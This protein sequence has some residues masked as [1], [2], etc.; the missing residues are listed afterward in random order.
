MENSFDNLQK[1]VSEINGYAQALQSA[2]EAAFNSWETLTR[3]PAALKEEGV[4]EQIF[5]SYQN[6]Q[7]VVEYLEKDLLIFE[8][9]FRER[10]KRLETDQPGQ[11]KT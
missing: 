1:R 2:L 4:M 7:A 10:R 9:N 8:E 6:L 5:E 3:D 11:L